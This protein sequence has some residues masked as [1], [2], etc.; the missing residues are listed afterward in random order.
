[1][2][3]HFSSPGSKGAFGSTIPY[4]EIMHLLPLIYLTCVT[5]GFTSQDLTLLFLLRYL[6]CVAVVYIPK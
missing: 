6:Y 2:Y 4:A 3:L 5:C 1:M